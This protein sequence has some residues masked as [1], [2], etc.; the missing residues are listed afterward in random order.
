MTCS[1]AKWCETNYQGNTS[2]SMLQTEGKK[3]VISEFKDRAI[4][5]RE[6][7]EERGRKRANKGETGEY[8]S[9]S[10][11][12][13]PHTPAEAGLQ[14]FETWYLLAWSWIPGQARNDRIYCIFWLGPVNTCFAPTL[15]REK[16]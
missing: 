7:G 15:L 9:L 13:R 1:L 2:Q 11:W 8:C 14:A 5:P 3:Q 16:A 6:T 12:Y 10:K 4:P